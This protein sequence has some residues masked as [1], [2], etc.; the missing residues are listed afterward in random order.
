MADSV[1]T[2][3]EAI[4]VELNTITGGLWPADRFAFEKLQKDRHDRAPRIEWVETGG[5]VQDAATLVG[6]QTG[7]IGVDAVELNV[8]IWHTD[9]EKCRDTLHKLMVAT[10]HVALGPNV[11]YG[12]YTWSEDAHLKSG[13]KLTMLV[14]LKIPILTDQSATV[15]T[16]VESHSQTPP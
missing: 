13:Q 8:T 3:V 5:S 1:E 2:L 4:R 9:K 14:M 12:S 16:T 15:E 10:R 11:S 6:G 7:T